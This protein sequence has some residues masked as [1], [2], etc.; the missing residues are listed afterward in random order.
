MCIRDSK[1]IVAASR[2]DLGVST[3]APL[4]ALAPYITSTIYAENSPSSDTADLVWDEVELFGRQLGR[5][6]SKVKNVQ[7]KVNPRSLIE[8]V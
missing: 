1:E 2:R 3:T 4:S 5:D 8:H 6:R 7:A